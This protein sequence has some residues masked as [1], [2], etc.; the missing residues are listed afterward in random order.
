MIRNQ[1]VRGSNPLIGLEKLALDVHYTEEHLSC[2]IMSDSKACGEDRFCSF[3][4]E[5]HQAALI[6]NVAALQASI[7]LGVD[8]NLAIDCESDNYAYCR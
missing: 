3:D 7:D 1:L 2:R 4:S 6:G 5:I 8:I